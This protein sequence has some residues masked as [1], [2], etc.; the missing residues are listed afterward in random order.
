MHFSTCLAK[1]NC[2]VTAFGRSLSILDAAINAPNHIRNIVTAC[3]LH[4]SRVGKERCF[5]NS[6]MNAAPCARAFQL[7]APPRR[8][9]DLSTAP[10]A[11]YTT[12]FSSFSVSSL[13]LQ[14]DRRLL[15]T[16]FD[17][18]DPPGPGL[19]CFL[20]LYPLSRPTLCEQSNSPISHYCASRIQSAEHPSF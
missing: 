6:P 8:A 13:S 10:F 9:Q 5:A 12:L 20:S 1:Y 16:S 18:K 17:V 19:L 11:L 4:K 15:I 14:R 3:D 2:G 7:S